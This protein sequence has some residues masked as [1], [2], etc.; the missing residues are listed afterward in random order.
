MSAIIESWVGNKQ[1]Q[2]QK[3]WKGF[4]Q[5][6]WRGM[7][8]D[9]VNNSSPNAEAQLSVTSGKHEATFLIKDF[10]PKP[11][12]CVEHH[13]TPWGYEGHFAKTIPTSGGLTVK[14]QEII[15]HL[16]SS[17]WLLQSYTFPSKYLFSCI[18]PILVYCIIS[19][20]NITCVISSLTPTCLW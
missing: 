16:T 11:W 3:A 8:V 18:L 10:C 15:G 6:V 7:C 5:C 13:S 17:I 19:H 2:K 12:L 1:Q 9:Q 14:D 20:L 4:L